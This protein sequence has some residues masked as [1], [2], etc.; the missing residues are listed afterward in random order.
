[1]ICRCAGCKRT[2]HPSKFAHV[3]NGMCAECWKKGHDLARP[4]VQKL[5]HG[6][7]VIT[8]ERMV[9]HCAACGHLMNV[10]LIRGEIPE[11]IYVSTSGGKEKVWFCACCLTVWM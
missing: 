6:Y 11:E 2:I 10:E 5:M 4:L 1:M 9:C 3:Y 7:E 8:R